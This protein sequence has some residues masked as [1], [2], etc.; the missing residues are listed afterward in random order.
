MAETCGQLSTA[1]HSPADLAGQ[2][3]VPHSAGQMD[4]ARKLCVPRGDCGPGSRHLAGQGCCSPTTDKWQGCCRWQR[5]SP[6][7]GGL[8]CD[9][10]PL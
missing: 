2:S 1:H 9:E 6:C 7:S 4:E 3:S 8:L 10:N 5:L